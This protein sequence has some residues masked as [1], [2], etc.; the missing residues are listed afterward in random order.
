KQAEI[1]A[2][3]AQIEAA[4]EKV[5]SRSLA[6][7]KSDDIQ[8]VVQE[9]Y[10]R[11]LE[12]NIRLDSV[13]IL[14][15][16][17][18]SRDIECWTGSNLVKYQQA[19]FPYADHAFLREINEAHEN[20]QEFFKGWYTKEQKDEIFKYFFEETELRLVPADRK[21]FVFS[22]QHHACSI[23]LVQNVGVNL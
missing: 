18:G 23:A 8:H 11:L 21:K 9:L 3:E 1:Q 4:L 6:M 7:H 17:E 12:F 13:N 15:F 10:I 19:R 2:R 16:K 14:F 5:R 22:G 20:G